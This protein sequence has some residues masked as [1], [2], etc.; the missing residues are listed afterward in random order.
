M[1]PRAP[2]AARWSALRHAGKPIRRVLRSE[3]GTSSRATMQATEIGRG[4]TLENADMKKAVTSA[5][6]TNP[7]RRE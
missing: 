3:R 4:S 1:R 6:R 5:A 2:C 7:R